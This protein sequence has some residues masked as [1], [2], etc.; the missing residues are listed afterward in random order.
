MLGNDKLLGATLNSLGVL[1][2]ERNGDNVRAKECYEEALPLLLKVGDRQRASYC[3][4]NLGN[5]AY[6]DGE[7]VRA[8]AQLRHSLA[9]AEELGDE[10]HRAYCL[11]SLGEV[12]SGLGDLENAS[13]LLEEGLALCRRLG[14]RMTEGGTLL[15][16]AQVRRRQERFAD[17]AA[18]AQAGLRL[19][20]A[21]DRPEGVMRSWLNLADTAAAEADWETAACL[22]SAADAALA[23]FPTE[24]DRDRAAALCHSARAALTPAA[25]AA[26]WTRGRTLTCDDYGLH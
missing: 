21:V 2:N 18:E 5:I 12:F 7:S 25:F 10:W 4:H 20:A 9:L 3:L 24:D 14:D 6:D 17:A 23:V 11:R 8:V 13:C 26:A 1:A 22:L 15:I 16:L 19:Y